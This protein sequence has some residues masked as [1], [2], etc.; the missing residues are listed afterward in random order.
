MH[1]VVPLSRA[2]GVDMK[3]AVEMWCPYLARGQCLLFRFWKGVYP[4][5]TMFSLHAASQ[6]S[7]GR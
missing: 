6:A 7:P 5:D 3:E 4:L 1:E 2:L